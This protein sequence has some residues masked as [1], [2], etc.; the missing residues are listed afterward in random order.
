MLLSFLCAKI[1][2]ALKK[3]FMA[4]ILAMLSLSLLI[5]DSIQTT[6]QKIQRSVH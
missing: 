5:C 1:F 4:P 6:V 2:L 3:V